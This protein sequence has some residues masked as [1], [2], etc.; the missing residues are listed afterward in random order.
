MQKLGLLY[1]VSF[2]A[3]GRMSGVNLQN[4]ALLLKVKL[5]IDGME[6]SS[7]DKLCRLIVHF[8]SNMDQQ[9]VAVHAANTLRVLKPNCRSEHLRGPDLSLVKEAI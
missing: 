1:Y 6:I 7:V 8:N 4:L 2:K 9:H 3:P 5:N